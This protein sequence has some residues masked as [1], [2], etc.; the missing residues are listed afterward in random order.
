MRTVT[1]WSLCALAVIAVLVLITEHRMHL[2]EVLVLLLV[3]ACPL[4]H[5]LHQHGRHKSDG[6][7]HSKGEKHA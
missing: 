2:D 6:H 7:Q 4:M 1:K 3:L 5:L